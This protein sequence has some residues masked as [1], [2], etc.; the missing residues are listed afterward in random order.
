MGVSTPPQEVERPQPE[1]VSGPAAGTGRASRWTVAAI[2][3]L[4]SLSSLLSSTTVN[5]AIPDLQQVF[6]AS[7]TDVQ[8]VVTGYLLGLS[9]TIP[10][11]GWATDRFGSKRVYLV[12]LALFTV[13]SVL[14]GL[15]WS[16]Q[17]EIAFRVVQGLA[18]GMIM[19]VGM[20]ILMR[21]TP[22]QERGRMMSVIGVPLMLGP[23]L[24]PTLGGAVIQGFDWRAIFWVNVPVGLL[25]LLF[26]WLKMDESPGGAAGR[27]DLLG[28]LTASPGVALLIYGLTQAS[29]RGWGSVQALLPMGAAVALLAGFTAWELRQEHPLLDLRIFGNPAYR[30][31]ITVTVIVAAALFGPVFL[32]PVFLEQVQHYT[33]ISAGLILGAQGVGAALMMPISGW[34]TDRY[35]ARPVVTFGVAVLTGATLLLTGITPSTTTLDWVVLLGLRGVGMGFA[36]MPAFSSAYTGLTA[37]QIGR[38]TAMSNTLQRIFSSLGVAV[39]ATVLTARVAAHVQANGR[40]SL[41]GITSA[42][43]ETFWV[44]SAMVVLA[45]PAALLMRRAVAPGGKLEAARYPLASGVAVLAGAGSLYFLAVAFQLASVPPGWPTW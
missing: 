22:P 21:M 16:I 14:C 9:A 12:T 41:I 15:A 42:F 17:S 32:A 37:D 25:A 13:A 5:V 33:L 28:W 4:G 26:A 10:L 39:M 8:W 7:L 11:S 43:D 1:P 44:A 34:L 18:G 19:P 27:F 29:E 45:L 36:M 3:A 35:G 30:S 31:A 38:A 20:A 2:V 23:A 6:H 24:G 40:P